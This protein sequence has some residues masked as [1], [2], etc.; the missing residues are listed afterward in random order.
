MND[1]SIVESFSKHFTVKFAP[2]MEL[3][4]AAYKIRHS[5]YSKELGWEPTNEN[6]M[7][8]DEYDNISYHCVLVHKRTQNFVGCIR[9]IIP[10][11][12]NAHLKLPFEKND[13]QGVNLDILNVDTLRRG[14][15][16]EISRLAVLKSFRRGGGEKDNISEL[17]EDQKLITE[18]EK[19]C[20]SYI[21]IALYLA[22]IVLADLC[23]HV[24][25]FLMTE[26]KIKRNLRKIGINL[27]Q[28]GD[29]IEYKGSRTLFFLPRNNFHSHMK[30]EMLKFYQEI[31]QNIKLQLSFIPFT[32]PI[33]K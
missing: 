20:F 31:H 24:G 32:N 17:N 7:E 13:L 14:S 25:I 22:G 21:S 2:T 19:S 23:N 29:E 1:I 3:K 5:V 16:G 4:Q 30:G 8:I 15:F 6:E 9:L 26:N 28:V 27:I 11:M 12:D 10:P 18:N 33:D